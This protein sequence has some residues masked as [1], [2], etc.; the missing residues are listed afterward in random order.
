MLTEVVVESPMLELV[1]RL[2]HLLGQLIEPDPNQKRT[3]NGIVLKACFPKV[4][5]KPLTMIDKMG[6]G[7][8]DLTDQQILAIV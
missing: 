7:I 2:S 6:Q 8:V 4:M 5:G 1:N 3:A